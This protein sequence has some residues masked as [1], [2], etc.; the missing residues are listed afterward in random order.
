MRGC[1]HPPHGRR[2][3]RGVRPALPPDRDRP[4]EPHPA[5]ILA[6][7][8]RGGLLVHRAVVARGV[9][10]AALR[11]PPRDRRRRPGR[12][13]LL[14]DRHAHRAVG[15]LCPGRL[16]RHRLPP[17]A[18][19]VHDDPVALV[20]VPRR[21]DRR[22]LGQPRRPRHG[23]PARLD[24]AHTDLPAPHGRGQATREADVTRARRGDD[25][26]LASGLAPRPT[27][28]ASASSRP[29]RTSV[30]VAG[31][32]PGA[33]MVPPS[34]LVS[35]PSPAGGLR[36]AWTP[37]AGGWCWPLSGTTPG[38]VR[39]P[40]ARSDPCAAW[41][42]GPSGCPAAA[43]RRWADSSAGWRYRT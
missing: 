26:A 36:P 30:T 18:A 3:A 42:A 34:S 33:A 43:W 37:P 22:A 17:D 12:G 9:P 13:Q 4:R 15:H 35:R 20:P 28:R 5:P 19:P 31:V 29:H 2:P 8:G 25:L 1:S 41:A 21:P 7:V 23:P 6:G 10:R 24:S 14:H 40:A 38:L 16:D 11:D 27:R 32:V 39:T